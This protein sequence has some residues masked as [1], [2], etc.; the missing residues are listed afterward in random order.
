M[1][2][3]FAE[4]TIM[5]IQF[6]RLLFIWKVITMLAHLLIRRRTVARIKRLESQKCPVD[7]E[8]KGT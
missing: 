3:N 1:A 2:G 5:S 8:S 4:N 6:G 7:K